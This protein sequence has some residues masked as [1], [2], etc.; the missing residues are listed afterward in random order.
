MRTVKRVYLYVVSLIAIQLVGWG[1]IF[2]FRQL[3]DQGRTYS[4]AEWGGLEATA[5]FVAFI[6]IG[7]PLF[8]IHWWSIRFVSE[9][10]ERNTGLRK[11]YLYSNLATWMG[12]LLF[13]GRDLLQNTLL[14]ITRLK[15]DGY[16]PWANLFTLLIAG[17]LWALHAWWQRADVQVAPRS[18]R[19]QDL[20]RAYQYLFAGSGLLLLYVEL[21][22]LIANLLKLLADSAF[23]DNWQELIVS[24]LSGLIIGVALVLGYWRP[25]QRRVKAGDEQERQS[26]LR[27]L[28]LHL[29]LAIFALG[30][31][32]NVV[33]LFSDLLQQALDVI[34]GYPSFWIRAALPIGQLLAGGL[35]GAYQTL[36]IFRDPELGQGEGWWRAGKRF[37]AYLLATIGL[38]MFLLGLIQVL[39]EVLN[40]AAGTTEQL[41]GSEWLGFRIVNPLMMMIVGFVTWGVM[42]LLRYWLPRA[43]GTEAEERRSLW[44]RMYASFFTF[45]GIALATYAG[46]SLVR[47]IVRLLF[48]AEA[49]DPLLAGVSTEITLLL[50]GGIAWLA[51]RFLLWRDET[52]WPQDLAARGFHVLVIDGQESELGQAVMKHLKIEL[53]GA[54]IESLPMSTRAT[55]T[56][57]EADVI[58]GSW[59]IADRATF[60][61][62]PTERVLIP[63]KQGWHWAGVEPDDVDKLAQHAAQAARQVADGQ[64]IRPE[65][66]LPTYAL[67]ATASWVFMPVWF[68]LLT[69]VLLGPVIQQVFDEIVMQLGQ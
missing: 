51:F 12:V 8:A 69:L 45:V 61:D 30:V 37:Y 44:R 62:L 25:I 23:R 17:L 36:L 32:T 64:R 41:N 58:I 54:K 28:Y 6:L 65:G 56:L 29:L 2:L 13:A 40:R 67:A 50:V 15:L 19:G 10:Q 59:E 47:L 20:R 22:N 35:F 39:I 5:T 4:F 52:H 9:P 68:I 31:L 57:S 21:A 49:P 66:R 1:G 7:L 46:V 60:A 14:V 27:T 26:G 24:P 42:I 43:S 38:G 55:S 33:T 34:G 53:P 3:A 18:Q 63:F 48:G 11:F 16:K